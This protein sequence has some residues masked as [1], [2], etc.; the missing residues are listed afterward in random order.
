MISTQPPTSDTLSHWLFILS[1][2]TTS[3]QTQIHLNAWIHLSHFDTS[4]LISMVEGQ[5]ELVCVGVWHISLG[6]QW[7]TEQSGCKSP[8]SAVRNSRSHSSASIFKAAG[9]EKEQNDEKPPSP[10]RNVL[11]NT[12][13]RSLSTHPHVSGNLSEAHT[14]TEPFSNL[15]TALHLLFVSFNHWFGSQIVQVKL[16]FLTTCYI[17]WAFIWAQSVL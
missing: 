7:A 16:S 2:N 8:I 13:A 1:M 6:F 14:A 17:F 9:H 3:T 10:K 4:V 11:P 12:Q 15:A 5:R